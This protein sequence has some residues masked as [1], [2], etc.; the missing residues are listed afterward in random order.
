MNIAVNAAALVSAPSIVA[1]APSL[2]AGHAQDRD[3]AERVDSFRKAIIEADALWTRTAE[4]D[5]AYERSNGAPPEVL[6]VT[7]E[8][9]AFGLKTWD[10]R[11]FFSAECDLHKVRACQVG[12]NLRAAARAIE[13]VSAHAEWSAK[14]RH[15]T[16][17]KSIKRAAQRASE[18]V[19]R[20]TDEICNARAAD[21]PGIF[22]KARCCEIAHESGWDEQG[23]DIARSIVS[24]IMRLSRC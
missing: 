8:D 6:R 17:A 14:R 19:S 15:P 5:E 11:P 7:P 1:A 20:M 23:E 24:D 16:G 3:L 2:A 13:I 10:G 4:N 22:S 18:R 21:M 12:S 9:A